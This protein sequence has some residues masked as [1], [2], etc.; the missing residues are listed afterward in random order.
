MPRNVNAPAQVLRSFT[1]LLTNGYPHPYPDDA[2]DEQVEQWAE[3]A[4]STLERVH[5]VVH[6][7]WLHTVTIEFA[8]R[9]HYHAARTRF[10]EWRA[11][12][13]LVLEAP[14]S[15]EEGYEHPAIIAAGKA[16]C[17]FILLLTGEHIDMPITPITP[18]NPPGPETAA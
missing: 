1:L 6:F 17:G 10:P 9:D 8:D 3:A 18:I 11:W 2:T 15:S 5:G 4:G 13:H 12:S 7:E 14:T 16:Y